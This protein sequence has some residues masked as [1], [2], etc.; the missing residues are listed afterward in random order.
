MCY[1]SK[2][3]A[4]PLEQEKFIRRLIERGHETPLEFA[5]TEF[6]ITT[7]RGILAELT[8]HR[9]ASFCVESSRY[10]RYDGLRFILPV[11]ASDPTAPQWCEWLQHSE[12][13]YRAA[14]DNGATPQVARDV[15]PL[16]TAVSLRVC[17]N[18]REWRH[19][20]RLRTAKGAHPKMRALMGQ[21]LAWFRENYPVIVEDIQ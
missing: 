7:D 18:W 5:H 19:I 10:C 17:A 11:P 16:C 9:H 13:S 3:S 14:I 20:L 15:L 6:A 8:R 1:Q 4:T 12:F 2:K 21:V